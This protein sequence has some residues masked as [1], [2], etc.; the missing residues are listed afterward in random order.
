MSYWLMKY[1]FL[2]PLLHAFFGPKPVGLENVP[3]EGPAI[4]AGNH[5]SPLDTVLLPLVVPHRQVVFLGKAEY[6]RSWK[7]RWFFKG[8]G[9]IPIQ[10]GGPD[11]ATALQGA[12][13]ALKEGKLVGIFPEG[14]RSPDGRMYRGRTGVARIALA[15]RVPV[16]PAAL[17]GTFEAMPAGAKFPKRH[18]VEVRFGPPLRFDEFAEGEVDRE[19]LRSVTDRIME[20]IRALSGQEYVDE[21]ASEVKKRLA[22]GE[23]R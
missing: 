23:S 2:G 19:V 14:T 18:P 20:A 1:V 4:I 5:V 16:I 15:S 17:I 21:Y 22:R 3:P 12:V 11:S 13:G 6:F 9:V 8:A 7:T 10:R